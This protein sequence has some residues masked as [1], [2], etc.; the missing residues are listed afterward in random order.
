MGRL[1][2]ALRQQPLEI[3]SLSVFQRQCTHVSQLVAREPKIKRRRR[4]FSEQLRYL[5]LLLLLLLLYE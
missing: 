3:D 4:V 1:V 2:M 5:L